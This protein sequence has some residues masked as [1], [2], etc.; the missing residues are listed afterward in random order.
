MDE[1]DIVVIGAGV[2]GLSAAAT[3]ARRGA[4]VAVVEK[5]GAGGQ[6][7][8]V[9]RIENFPGAVEPVAGFELGPAMQEQAEQA[10]AEFLLD[11]VEEVLL[12]GPARVLR[13]SQGE[14]TARALIVAAGSSRRALGVPGEERLE[15]RGVS[16]CASCDGPL[17]RGKTVAVIGGGDSAFDEALILATHAG[18]V[19]LIHRGESFRAAK[20]TV[21]K[22][23]ALENVRICLNS[24]VEEIIGDN[25]VQGLLVRDRITGA[26]RRESV[27]G[28]FVY[29]GLEPNTDFLKGKLDLAEDGRVLTDRFMQTSL[30][31]VFAAGDIRHASVAL[32]AEAAG[33]GATAAI[34][35]LNYLSEGFE[36]AR[37]VE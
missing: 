16:H 17:H 36:K 30:P 35:A 1:F 7:M 26:S 28:V 31:G 9:E 23:S 22:V 6:I 25:V 15:G 37:A 5:L 14:I 13:C 18:Q 10:G 11:A 2:A 24:T 29:V 32:L 12:D 34:A 19:L 27:D 33:D 4:R 3:A 8:T 20:P 21:E